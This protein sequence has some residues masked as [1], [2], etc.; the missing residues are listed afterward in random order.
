MRNEA[1]LGWRVR[2]RIECGYPVFDVPDDYRSVT[3]PKGVTGSLMGDI[4][5][6]PQG[7]N[8]EDCHRFAADIN[9]IKRALKR[10]ILPNHEENIRKW[11]NYWDETKSL[12]G[13]DLLASRIA[14]IVKWDGIYE[15]EPET[16]KCASYIPWLELV[17]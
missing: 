9:R 3:I 1:I 4:L 5:I 10:D 17:E 7:V 2:N 13:E 6:F 16:L 14:F 8:E 11:L 12:K 15:Q